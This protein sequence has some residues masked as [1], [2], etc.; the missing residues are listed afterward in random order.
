MRVLKPDTDAQVVEAIREA[1][2]ARK[3]LAVE[4]RGTMRAFGRAVPAETVLRLAGLT[5]IRMYEPDEMVFTARAGTPLCEINEALAAKGQCLAFEPGQWGP[6]WGAADS[7]TIGGTIAAAVAGP[8]RFA[9]GAA[10]DHLL[11]FVAVNGRGERFKAGG[12]VVKNV[13]GYD[14]PK[15]AAGSFGTLFA[16]TEV[17]LRAV[18][19]GAA[20]VVLAIENLEPAPALRTL[21]T[22]AASPLD[23]TGLAHLPRA[24]ASRV[25]G[26]DAAL[27]LIRLEGQ[28]EGVAARADEITRSFAPSARKLDV[29]LGTSLFHAVADVHPLFDVGTTLW[30]ISVPPTRAV[31]LLVRLAPS[32]WIADGA[33]GIF[34][35]AFVDADDAARTHAAARGF[36]GHAT[37]VRAGLTRSDEIFP[38]LEPALL[39]L[40]KQLKAAFDPAGILNPGRMYKDV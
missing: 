27:T 39:A 25:T 37:L 1:F 4:G 30:R 11:G 34:W 3:P 13:T 23:P 29:E 33:G 8:R 9:A 38:P 10:R 21:R 5:G 18:P 22:I 16:L 32:S 36:G 28:S 6:L 24:A 19:R 2:E 7:A 40:T 35:F 26:R 31:E 20:A 14:L 17:T 15:L 12:R